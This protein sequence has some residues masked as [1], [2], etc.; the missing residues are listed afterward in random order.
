MELR[1]RSSIHILLWFFFNN[2]VRAVDPNTAAGSLPICAQVCLAS[3]FYTCKC[4]MLDFKC[5]CTCSSFSSNAKTC[6]QNS[7]SSNLQP[8]A[9]D[10]ISSTCATATSISSTPT[11]TSNSNKAT[12]TSSTP[13]H[14]TTTSSPTHITTPSSTLGTSTVSTSDTGGVFGT[15]STS[16]TNVGVGGSTTP[17]PTSWGPYG[18]NA[19]GYGN[20]TQ[21]WNM[22][23]S[24]TVR[25]TCALQ[26]N[27]D[28]F[29]GTGTK[30][31]LE[32]IIGLLLWCFGLLIL[33]I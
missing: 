20:A 7:C 15:K 32:H 27:P 4:T 1:Y 24:G 11:P 26:A 23:A 28:P 33:R 10:M 19:T 2:V 18:G 8:P 12:S 17:T 13:T 5:G 22:T 25:S 6:I 21:C 31:E 3:A 16:T 14:I 9:L 30:A 29:T